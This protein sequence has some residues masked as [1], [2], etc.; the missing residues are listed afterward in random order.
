M[1]FKRAY[2]SVTIFNETISASDQSSEFDLTIC[3]SAS[4]QIVLSAGSSADFTATLQTSHTG[5][6]SWDDFPF[7]PT[8]TLSGSTDSHTFFFSPQLIKSIPA[9][10]VRVQ[11]TRTGGSG[12]FKI[13]LFGM[14][15][16]E[17]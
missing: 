6:T 16:Q 3:N 15:E 4:I 1:T 17:V 13:T 10:R 9:P 12:T 2:D 5:S 14:S 7:S 8:G 11:L